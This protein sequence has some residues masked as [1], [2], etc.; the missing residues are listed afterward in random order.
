MK[1]LSLPAKL[2]IGF[3]LVG[4]LTL[5]IT[6]GSMFW[7]SRSNL[8]AQIREQLKNYISLASL[9][10][11]SSTISGLIQSNDMTAETYQVILNQLRAMVK[12]S[13]GV[14]NVYI[15]YRNSSGNIAF[16][17]DA[18]LD[19][20]AQAG[21]VYSNPGP[22]LAANF[23]RSASAFTEAD[24][25]TDAW[26]TWLSGYAPIKDQAGRMV[27]IIGVDLSAQAVQDI[28]TSAM[29]S[30]LLACLVSAGLMAI[31][32]YFVSRYFLSP[33]P[34]LTRYAGLLAHGQIPSQAED[35]KQ[36]MKIQDQQDEIGAFGREFNNLINY[37]TEMTHNAQQ[38]ANGDLTVEVLPHSEDDFLGQA[39]L[40]MT[41]NLRY[42]I[43]QV[44]ENA[45]FLTNASSQ[46][47][48]ASAQA[49][50]VTTQIS[51][52]VQMVAL[53]INEQS[54][55][56]NDTATAVDEMGSAI[57]RVAKGA[58]DQSQAV[59]K[60]SII[61]N[62]ISAAIKQV[63]ENAAASAKGADQAAETARRGAQT[64][65]E[66]ISGMQAIK[67]KVGISASKVQEMGNRSDQIG[68]IVETIDDIASQTN[69]LALNAA[70]E[71]AR[72]GEHGKGFAVVA[73]EVRK[74]AERSSSSTKEIAS[75]IHGIQKILAETMS[76]MQDGTREVELGVARAN[77]ADAALNNILKAVG[78]VNGQVEQIASASLQITHSSGELVRAVE[79]VA[80][81]IEE[82]MAVTEQ[83][84]GNSHS[85]SQAIKSIARVSEENSASIEEVT[86]NTEEMTAQVEEVSASAQSLADMARVL[87]EVVAQFHLETPF[88]GTQ[89][90]MNTAKPER[91]SE[92]RLT[93]KASSYNS[94][95][96]RYKQP[97]AA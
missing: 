89:P 68:T 86:A 42:L 7:I 4:L 45:T 81:V 75:L 65:E 32:T 92:I 11:N 60:A 78:I 10:M 71:A 79:T 67:N 33:L 52:V 50:Q 43:S 5:T 88:A 90:E 34:H 55:S 91:E 53:G 74:L 80:V 96:V 56:V 61:T 8:R 27:A 15:M 19:N 35:Q 93:Q 1:K 24:L 59:G 14:A 44:A 2:T 30:L 17:F 76:A 62:Q 69:L 82:N 31:F 48:L 12:E 26:G 23:D 6:A 66:T 77:Q 73:D 51:D 47:A 29:R 38:I 58:Q 54:Y 18:D 85:V 39:F 64:I 16:L 20:P 49:G 72:A 37:F 40:Q 94:E 3:L 84:T 87:Q 57:E 28:E 41:T 97:A 9:Q 83:M 22:A 21:E 13:P 70:I 25:Y 63:A 46:L 95:T 36:I